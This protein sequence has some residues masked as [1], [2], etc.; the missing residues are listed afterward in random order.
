MANKGLAILKIVEGLTQGMV[1]GLEIK[2][3][4]EM[5][6]QRFNLAQKQEERAQ[7][8]FEQE[9]RFREKDFGL[10]EK[11]IGLEERQLER[12]EQELDKPFEQTREAERLRFVEDLERGT[13]KQK[14][15]VQEGQKKKA[16]SK[17]DIIRLS[18]KREKIDKEFR[19]MERLYGSIDRLKQKFQND[20]SSLNPQE[21]VQLVRLLVPLSEINPGVVREGEVAL[22]RE[23]AGALDRI[24]QLF[25][26]QVKGE[27]IGDKVVEDMF[28][29]A[30]TLK[31]VVN[32]MKADAMVNIAEEGKSF[33]LDMDS[34]KTV[35]GDTN[36]KI[37]QDPSSFASFG[38]SK[39]DQSPERKV[40]ING[41]E[42]IVTPDLEKRARDIFT[43]KRGQASSGATGSF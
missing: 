4:R 42:V 38:K 5:D 33:G 22:V 16:E 26:Q 12:Q 43:R 35:L 9:Q 39:D 28:K 15:E 29:T 7:S 8:R 19:P 6:Q 30:E 32:N 3:Q 40:N 37:I 1:Q 21:R 24:S 17:K 27:A 41:K 36:L 23:Q 11:R 14:L 2:R 10:R 20:P 34:L 31:P 13:Q 25:N 18:T